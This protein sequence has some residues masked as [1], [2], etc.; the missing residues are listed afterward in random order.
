MFFQ[1]LPHPVSVTDAATL[2]TILTPLAATCASAL[3]SVGAAQGQ[4][5]S[6]PMVGGIAP[7]AVLGVLMLLQSLSMTFETAI[8]NAVPVCIPFLNWVYYF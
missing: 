8:L 5:T 7:S 3:T 6:L 1:A 4:I 2:A